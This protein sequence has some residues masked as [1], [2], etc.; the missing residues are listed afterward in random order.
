VFIGTVE[1]FMST[2][3][4][5]FGEALSLVDAILEELPAGGRALDASA[6]YKAVCL[7]FPVTQQTF[8]HACERASQ[9]GLIRLTQ[10]NEKLAR[11]GRMG[12]LRRPRRS[13]DWKVEANLYRPVLRYLRLSF[14]THPSVSAGPDVFA[15]IT[16]NAHR[17]QTVPD[18]ILLSRYSNTILRYACPDLYTFEVKTRDNIKNGSPAQAANQGRLA[19]YRYL[20]WHCPD[21][22]HRNDLKYTLRARCEALKVGLI[23]LADPYSHDTYE[24]AVTAPRQEIETMSA[25]KAVTALL[26]PNQD[27]RVRD[28]LQ[29]TEGTQ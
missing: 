14:P 7:R 10:E 12:V 2:V 24:L 20:V 19:N 6:I 21:G 4:T 25:D 5:L 8:Q 9:L 11:A 13:V 23:V 1:F 17:V 15:A 29:R 16:A 22:G 18:L 28:W 26:T 3:S 27:R